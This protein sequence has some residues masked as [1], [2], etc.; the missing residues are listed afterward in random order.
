LK[1]GGFSP[2][3]NRSSGQLEVDAAN[4]HEGEAKI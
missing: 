2:R 1:E 3:V 4:Y